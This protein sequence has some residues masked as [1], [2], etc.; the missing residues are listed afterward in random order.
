VGKFAMRRHNWVIQVGFGA[1]VL[2]GSFFTTLWLTAPNYPETRAAAYISNDFNLLKAAR[3]F[4][5]LPLSQRMTGNIDT[6]NRI[7]EREVSIVGWVAD[8]EGDGTPTEVL[9]FAGE[10]FIAAT[11]TKGERSDVTQALH[12]GFG[13]EKNVSFSVNFDCRPG[14]QF[15]VVAIAAS[16]HYFPFGS[17]QCP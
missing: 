2:V 4:V 7:N 1:A 16:K 6:T 12:S 5:V 14:D 3:D 11:Q 13:P 9:V 8:M 17:Y 15:V 10:A